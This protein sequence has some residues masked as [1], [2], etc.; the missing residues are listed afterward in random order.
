MFRK[1]EPVYFQNQ[2]RQINLHF[3][4]ITTELIEQKGPF[5]MFKWTYWSAIHGKP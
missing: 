2:T 1:L 5:V 4:D 3:G